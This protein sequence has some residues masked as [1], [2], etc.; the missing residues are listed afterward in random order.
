M[1]I[2]AEGLIMEVMMFSEV[3][4]KLHPIFKYIKFVDTE[5]CMVCQSQSE[6]SAEK[7]L[8]RDKK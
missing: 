6:Y 1:P 3:K 8:C 5:F 4:S 7:W 2:I